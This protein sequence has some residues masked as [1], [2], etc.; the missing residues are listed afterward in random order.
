MS[1]TPDDTHRILNQADALMNRHRGHRTFV[2][3]N[4]A[5][6]TASATTADAV[7][8]A[9]EDFP[10]LTEVVSEF[11][12]ESGNEISG[13]AA[14]KQKADLLAAQRQQIEDHL[15]RWL[16][17]RLPDEVLRVMDGV[18]DQLIGSLV[19][20]MREELLPELLSVVASSDNEHQKTTD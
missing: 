4:T 14:E 5:E 6:E 19:S 13:I 16:D 7:P 18:S 11:A 17:N 9:D 1:H 20:R 8:P 12:I 10:V 15:E 3:K 2:A